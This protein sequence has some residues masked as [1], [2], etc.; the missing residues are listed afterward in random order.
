MFEFHGWAK[1]CR[2][3]KNVD[4]ED[5]DESLLDNIVIEIR[6]YMQNLGWETGVLDIRIINGQYHFWTSGFTNHKGAE[7]QELLELYRF[8]GQKAPGSYGV[9]YTFDSGTDLGFRENF[10]VYVLV[11]GDLLEIPDPFLS[12]FIPVVEDPYI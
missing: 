10:I 5:D 9:L 12:P 8:I 7:A 6:D 1:I 4:F 2:S 3:Y 11:R